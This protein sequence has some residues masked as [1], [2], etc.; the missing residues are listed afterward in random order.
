MAAELATAA[1]TGVWT[2]EIAVTTGTAAAAIM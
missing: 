2:G 1:V